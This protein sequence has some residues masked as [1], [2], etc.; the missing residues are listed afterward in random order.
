MDIGP[1]EAEPFWTAFLRKLARRGLRGVKLVISDTHEG[2]RAAVSKILNATWQRCRVGPLKKR[3]PSPCWTDSLNSGRHGGGSG[4][5]GGGSDDSLSSSCVAR[6]AI[7]FPTTMS[8]P[9]S[10]ACSTWPGFARRSRSGLPPEKWP[11]MK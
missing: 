2:I 5:W 6:S 3:L 10:I 1:S 4:C 7:W 9:G 8:S 11:S